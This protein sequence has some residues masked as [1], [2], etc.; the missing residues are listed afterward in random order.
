MWKKKQK[1]VSLISDHGDSHR[2]PFLTIA[3]ACS[4]NCRVPREELI[5]YKTSM[6]PRGLFLY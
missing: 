4:E 1:T 5:D 2:Y 3:A 6:P